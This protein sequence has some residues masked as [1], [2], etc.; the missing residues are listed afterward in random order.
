MQK[1]K[2]ILGLLF[3]T[4]IWGS[5]FVAQSAGMDKIGPFTFQAI[6]CFLAVVALFLLTLPGLRN[7]REFARKWADPKLWLAGFICGCALMV[8]ASLQQVALLYTDAGKAGFIT[9]M[10][11]I[12]VPIL[13]IFLRKRP[14][15]TAW[16]GTGVAAVGMY[17]LCG[18]GLHGF[19]AGDLMLIGSAVSFAVQITFIDRF[20]PNA[21]PIRLNCVQALVVSVFSGIIM[22]LWEEPN[23][24]DICD[25]WL[26]LCYAGVL[27]M[28]LAYTLQIVGQKH[29]S[30]TP[31]ALIMSLE[32]VFAAISSAWILGERM[33]P[34]ELIGCSLVFAAIL[35]SQIPIPQ[36]KKQFV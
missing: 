28:G 19:N 23:F 6:R 7:S 29:L 15:F 32:S 3:A 27:S 9:A 14:P 22:F 12:F 4:V 5:A 17:L 25:A 33:K 31:A 18:T 36:R 35:I 26:P 16:I 21:D 11:I 10:Y 13:G 30:P 1:I 20:A 24:G 2:G 8:A 34:T